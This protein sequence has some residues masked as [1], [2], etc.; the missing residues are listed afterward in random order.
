MSLH[1][2][3]ARLPASYYW[4]TAHYLAEMANLQELKGRPMDANA[5]RLAA[6][7]MA[8][9]YQTARAARNTGV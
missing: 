5:T 9:L 3:P 8:Q 2:L 6:I 7:T 1:T 4:Q